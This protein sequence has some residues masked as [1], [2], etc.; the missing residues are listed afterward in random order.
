MTFPLLATTAL[1]AVDITMVGTVLIGIAGFIVAFGLAVFVHELG[2]FLAAKLFR[3]PVERFVIGFDRDAMGFL[4]GCIWERK[5]GETVYGLSLVPL[6]GY[7]KMS[8]IVHPEIERYLDGEDQKK[9]PEVGPPASNAAMAPDGPRPD[10]RTTPSSGQSLQDQAMG[11]MAALYNRPFYQKLIIYSAGVIMNLV[12]AMVV[13]TAMYTVG[14]DRSAP[15]PART[16]WVAEDNAFH[17]L[18]VEPGTAILAINGHDT[19]ND[20]DVSEAVALAAAG[21]PSLEELGEEGFSFEEFW[22]QNEEL[23]LRLT[24]APSRT[25]PEKSDVDVL[26][27]REDRMDFF[28]F[29]SQHPAYIDALAPDQPAD[30]AGMRGGD[31]VVAING[32]PIVD[33]NHFTHIVRANPNTV[34]SMTVQRGEETAELEVAVGES[35]QEP[36]VGWVGVVRGNPEKIFEQEPFPTAL[37]NSPARVWGFTTFYVQQLGNLGGRAISGNISGV[38]Q[39][40]SGPVGIFRYAYRTA[41]QGLSDWLRFLMILNVALAVMNILPFPV[42]DGGHIV[43]AMYE[44]VF[45]RPV[46]PQILVPVLNGAVVLLLVFFVLVTFNDLWKI[47]S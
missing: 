40:L 19:E 11:D 17:A 45:K 14:F 36:G 16:A 41:T 15:A 43:F 35:P 1:L 7:V 4:P 8:G 12:L 46:P 3:V 30:K 37:L 20:Q 25:S 13:V 9:G 21:V 23:A 26:V 28:R 5:I 42:L 33:W 29:V 10:Y 18:G 31:I 32:D 34:M 44:A 22:A 6:G 24:L 38:S 47:F 2:H 39:D 27:T